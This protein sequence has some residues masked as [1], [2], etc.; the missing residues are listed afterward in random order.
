MAVFIARAARGVDIGDDIDEEDE[1][2]PD[3]P[4]EYWAG[5][6]IKACVDNDVVEGYA[7]GLYRPQNYVPRDEMAV[8]VSRA[9]GWS[10]IADDLTGLADYFDDVLTGHW[11]GEAIKDCVDNDVVQGYADNT[12]KPNVNVNRNQMA[13]YVYRALIRPSDCE[14]VLGGPAATTEDEVEPSGGEGEAEVFEPGDLSYYGYSDPHFDAEEEEYEDIEEGDV[15]YVA[16][17]AVLIGSGNIVFTLLGPDSPTTVEDTA[18]VAVNAGTAQAAVEAEGG[19]PYLVASYQIPTGLAVGEYILEATLPSS[20]ILE[21]G[22]F[23][24]E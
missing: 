21:M 14:V 8:Y 11:A 3:V 6:A 22:E 4:A 2:F 13:V 20:A 7:D 9:M 24:V 23:E 5:A 1:L 17:D 10:A 15:V 19:V 16:L 18:T 12:Y